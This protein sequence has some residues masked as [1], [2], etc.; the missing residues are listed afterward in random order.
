MQATIAYNR[1]IAPQDLG[2]GVSRKVLSHD[3][4]MMIVEVRFALG[5]VGAPHAHAHAQISYVLS[6]AFEFTRAGEAFRLDRGDAICFAPDAVHGARCLEAGAL[7]DVFAPPREDFL[8]KGE[9][10]Q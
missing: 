3:D 1:E 7:I 4:R 6:G 5:A 9:Q 10:A 2:G 8:P